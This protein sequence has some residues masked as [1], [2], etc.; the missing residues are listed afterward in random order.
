MEISLKTKTK[1]IILSMEEDLGSPRITVHI[2][3]YSKY[4]ISL[5]PGDQAFLI[6]EVQKIIKEKETSS[7]VKKILGI[8]NYLNL[9]FQEI[10][11]N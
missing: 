4:L 7:V 8:S 5:N 3:N 9:E 11:K 2:Y 1:E 6:E 10:N